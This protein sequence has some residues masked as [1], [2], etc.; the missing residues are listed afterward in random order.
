MIAPWKFKNYPKFPTNNENTQAITA[1]EILVTYALS[2]GKH[3]FSGMFLYNGI[4]L[5][6][7]KAGTICK[8]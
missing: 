8:Q 5:R 6:I 3:L 7:L 1:I 2:L 4:K